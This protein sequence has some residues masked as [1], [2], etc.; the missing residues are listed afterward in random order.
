MRKC[1]YV[2]SEL[3]LKN[4]PGVF[5]IL[6]PEIRDGDTCF[7]SRRPQNTHDSR[8]IW[9]WHSPRVSLACVPL[10]EELLSVVSLLLFSASFSIFHNICSSNEQCRKHFS[11]G[12]VLSLA[13]CTLFN[14]TTKQPLIEKK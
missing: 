13:T 7:Q 10:S 3:Y 1:N 11:K 14:G 12:Q 8:H 4:M 2:A 5:S 6:C 9:P